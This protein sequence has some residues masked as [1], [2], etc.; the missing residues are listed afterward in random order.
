MRA[1]FAK[2][3]KRVRTTAGGASGSSQVFEPP[4]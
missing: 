3:E 2:V 4:N 1:G